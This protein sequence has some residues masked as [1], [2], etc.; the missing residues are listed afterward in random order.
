MS[1]CHQIYEALV[2]GGYDGAVQNL[3]TSDGDT[4]EYVQLAMPK[5][6]LSSS[7]A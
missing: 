7:T 3:L 2:R 5:E 1:G 4:Q 6:V